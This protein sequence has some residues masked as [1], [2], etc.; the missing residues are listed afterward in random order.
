[1]C[2]YNLSEIRVPSKSNI[3]ANM[4]REKS[5]KQM[6]IWKF[7]CCLWFGCTFANWTGS[8][9]GWFLDHLGDAH[10]IQAFCYLL[11]KLIAFVL[12]NLCV[13]MLFN[14]K[15]TI[16][17]TLDLFKS[18]DLETGRSSNQH[19]NSANTD[20]TKPSIKRDPTPEIAGHSSSGKIESVDEQLAELKVVLKKINALILC[21]VAL[22]IF[23]MVAAVYESY[24]IYKIYRGEYVTNI[25]AESTVMSMVCYFPLWTLIHTVLLVYGWIPTEQAV[26]QTVQDLV[27]Y[28]TEETPEGGDPPDPESE[29]SPSGHGT[30]PTSSAT[31]GNS[32]PSDIKFDD[33]PDLTR[34]AI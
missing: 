5:R 34:F 4:M 33:V 19:D 9:Y 29:P 17:G 8:V 22:S 11:W 1:M 26:P 7:V 6:M 21:E 18:S 23:L 27:D 2:S 12:L 30:A 28:V 20:S 25:Y 13:S 3:V 24:V 10:H 14:I 31:P 16:S 15:S 32:L